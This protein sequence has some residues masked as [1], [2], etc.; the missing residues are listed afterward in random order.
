MNTEKKLYRLFEYQRFA[1]NPKLQKIIDSAHGKD[2]RELNDEDLDQVA[3]A[4]EMLPL[5]KNKVHQK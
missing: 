2:V 1:N 4:G 3:A 5:E